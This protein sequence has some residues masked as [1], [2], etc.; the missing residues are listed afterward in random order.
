MGYLYFRPC[1]ALVYGLND[2]G[3][4]PC[5]GWEFFSSLPRPDQPW[6]QPSLLSSGY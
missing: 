3:L 4:S 6:G 5:R 1:V 2:R